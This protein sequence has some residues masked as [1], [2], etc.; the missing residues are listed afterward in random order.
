M[1]DNMALTHYI[2]KVYADYLVAF[3]SLNIAKIAKFRG[4][5][6]LFPIF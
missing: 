5:I 2:N 6:G 1:P 3:S 4:A